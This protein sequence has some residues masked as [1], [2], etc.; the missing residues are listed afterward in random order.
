MNHKRKNNNIEFVINKHESSALQKTL[1]KRIKVQATVL[2]KI[3]A[4]CTSDRYLNF[5]IYKGLLKTKT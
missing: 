5:I 4:K 1:L 2:E 3:F